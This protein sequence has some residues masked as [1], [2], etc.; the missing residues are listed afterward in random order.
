[1]SYLNQGHKGNTKNTCL[2]LHFRAKTDGN[3]RNF[4][5]ITIPFP[6]AFLL[7]LH[8]LGSKQIYTQHGGKLAGIFQASIYTI[9]NKVK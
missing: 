2:R 4:L 3:E 1:M 7:G 9:M 6:T 8:Y 5:A